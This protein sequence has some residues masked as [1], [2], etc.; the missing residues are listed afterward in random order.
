MEVFLI[1]RNKLLLIASIFIFSAFIMAGCGS[2][3]KKEAAQG[4][5]IEYQYIQAED[6]KKNIDEGGDGYIILDVR[7]KEDY[8]S[9]HIKG[10]FSGDVD[11]IVSAED[12]ELA[13][14][15][16]K[17][18]LKEATGSEEGNKDSK[19]VLVC[20]S[21]KRYAQGATGI[22]SELGIPEGNIYTLEGGNK[23]WVE[24]GD[25]YISLME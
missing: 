3:S 16:L 2:D 13:T 6:L 5:T 18:A 19:Y 8:D 4:E 23:N 25:D 7:K 22:L 14:N 9:S 20:Y 24:L 11:S 17:A 12:K 21:G 10:A 15:N 1:M